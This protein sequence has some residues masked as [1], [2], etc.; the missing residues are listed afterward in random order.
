MHREGNPES[1]SHI[2]ESAFSQVG[3][4]LLSDEEKL[5]LPASTDVSVTEESSVTLSTGEGG[6]KE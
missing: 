1:P 3:G 2:L 5:S 6:T 4:G